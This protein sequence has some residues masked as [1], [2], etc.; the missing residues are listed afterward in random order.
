MTN[1]A[2]FKAVRQRSNEKNKMFR[3]L[4]IFLEL[5]RE[6]E[7]SHVKKRKFVSDAE[8]SS[9]ESGAATKS[10]AKNDAKNRRNFDAN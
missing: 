6:R 4:K 7:Y 1:I 3:G 5:A 9:A 8:N 10:S 2:T